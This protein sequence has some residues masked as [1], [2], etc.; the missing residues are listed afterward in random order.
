MV[1]GRDNEWPSIEQCCPCG[2]ALLCDDPPDILHVPADFLGS[3]AH[4]AI[5]CRGRAAGPESGRNHHDE[6]PSAR[7]PCAQADGKR[8][9]GA[10]RPDARRR[11]GTGG[12]HGTGGCPVNAVREERP[13]I[14]SGSAVSVSFRGLKALQRVDIRVPEGAIVGLVGPNGAGKSTLLG[15]LSGEVIA[16]EGVVRLAGED[17]SGVAPEARVRRG[18]ARTFQLPQLFEELTVREHLTLPRRLAQAPSRAWSDPLT[19]RFLHPDVTEDEEVDAL[20]QSLGAPGSEVA[21]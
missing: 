11:S 9:A 3:A 10:G 16:R 5:R 1:C 21:Q 2:W 18:L 20:L 12:S 6:R 17:V 14:L 13:D 7:G 15:V 4:A 8:K 19:G